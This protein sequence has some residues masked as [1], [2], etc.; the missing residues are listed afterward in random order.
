MRSRW[1]CVGRFP[2]R[3]RSIFCDRINPLAVFLQDVS[4]FLEDSINDD[5]D[6]TPMR[7]GTEEPS[8]LLGL[9]GHDSSSSYARLL[10]LHK[11]G[12]GSG[13][14]GMGYAPSNMLQGA[15]PMPVSS[16]SY[17]PSTSLMSSR[18]PPPAATF[19]ETMQRELM[20]RAGL[21]GAS[22][23]S[24]T[25]TGPMGLVAPSHAVAA[26]AL[27]PPSRAVAGG[28][29]SS[30]GAPHALDASAADSSDGICRPFVPQ[31]RRSTQDLP[32]LPDLTSQSDTGLSS[33]GTSGLL[34]KEDAA[35]KEASS[36]SHV[37]N[38]PG[39]GK[40]RLAL[41]TLTLL[42]RARVARASVAL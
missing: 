35:A 12:S 7:T 22:L 8:M 30:S 28:R 25:A 19:E 1:R 6:G 16:A 29:L 17:D 4:A 33:N 24:S 13:S 38:W 40:V 27:L 9:R 26:Q 39:C 20:R 31:A 10:G 18:V 11:S 5:T 3:A 41:R 32:D 42:T 15:L 14:S 21:N 37:C 34:A 36:R 23:F 2:P